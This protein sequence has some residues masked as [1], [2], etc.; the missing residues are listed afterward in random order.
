MRKRDKERLA[1]LEA[2][3]GDLPTAETREGREAMDII[4]RVA[5]KVKRREARAGDQDS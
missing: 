4:R 2:E 1:Q 5:A 3:I